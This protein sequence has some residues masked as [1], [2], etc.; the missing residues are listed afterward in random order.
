MRKH[1]HVDHKMFIIQY[2]ERDSRQRDHKIFFI[3]YEEKDSRA[4]M[5][6]AKILTTRNHIQRINEIKKSSNGQ[7]AFVFSKSSSSST[8]NHIQ[9]MS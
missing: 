1:T 4:N 3:Q 7:L 5:G 2:E 9:H 8:R 6:T